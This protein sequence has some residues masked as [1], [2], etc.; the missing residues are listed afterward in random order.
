MVRYSISALWTES[1][2]RLPGLSERGNSILYWSAT[3]RLCARCATD[4]LDQWIAQGNRSAADLTDEDLDEVGGD[5]VY[6]ADLP[7]SYQELESSH[8]IWCDGCDQEI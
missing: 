4:I 8:V 7:V 6:E 3:S 2:G 5:P 1:N